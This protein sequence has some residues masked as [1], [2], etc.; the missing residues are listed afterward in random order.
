MAGLNRLIL[1]ELVNVF[2]ERALDLLL[3]HLFEIDLDDWCK[4]T[5]YRGPEVSNEVIQWLWKCVRVWPVTN[6]R[7]AHAHYKDT[8]NCFRETKTA[9]ASSSPLPS[10]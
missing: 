10:A 2:D 8:G 5:D 3:R 6:L 7:G 1:L 4:F 9:I